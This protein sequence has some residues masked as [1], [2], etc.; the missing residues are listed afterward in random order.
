MQVTVNPYAT[1][2][3]DDSRIV[4]EN[5]VE[6]TR[7]RLDSLVPLTVA[8]WA[9]GG[10]PYDRLVAQVSDRCEID[11]GVADDLVSRLLENDVLVRDDERCEIPS[12]PRSWS[13]NRWD[14]AWLYHLYIRDFP[15]TDWEDNGDWK[16]D[17]DVDD[18]PPVYDRYED[19]ETLPLPAVNPV[20][21]SVDLETALSRLPV[22]GDEPH[23]SETDLDREDLSHLLY[24]G[25]GEVGRHD[26]DRA[27]TVLLKTCPSGGA[28]H[29]TEA[30]VIVDSVRG[31]ESGIYHYS[32]EHHGLDV[33]ERTDDAESLLRD[34][35]VDAD[36]ASPAV[37]IV[38]TSKVRR[39]MVK[40]DN[41]RAF[42]IVQHDIGH[43]LETV[44]L[45][46]LGR[47]RGV[48]FDTTFDSETLESHLRID[49][50]EEPLFG[51]VTIF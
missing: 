38:L 12:A 13:S 30:Y 37:A 24:Y 51:Y 5:P 41:S 18:L 40:Y 49:A 36:G 17:L 47:G 50:I 48:T 2:R 14:A 31:V 25:F 29:P 16:D 9:N 15:F 11:P 1:I 34:A 42:R 6:N 28:R 43:I 20:D 21:E 4:V 26:V 22:V 44:K 7:L 39:N 19:A 46:A 3:L 45:V 8:S 27:G 32:V 35:R 33:I 23:E 10:I